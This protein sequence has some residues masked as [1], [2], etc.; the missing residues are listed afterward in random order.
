MTTHGLS[1]D[2]LQFRADFEEC[3]LAP[4]VFGHRAHLRLAYVYLA[5]NDA[6]AAFGLMRDALRRFLRH[7]GIDPTKY[8]ET[9][10]RAWLLAV[11]HFM[12]RT[13]SASSAAAFIDANPT[14]L[15]AK[16]MMTHYS[17]ELLFSPEARG[18]FVE[19]DLAQI[20]RHG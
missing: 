15:D 7:H 8:H 18:Q 9:L 4:E 17:A 3:R 20:P 16:I 2:D 11:R 12:E 5:E 14:L 13:A 19:P 1:A 10:T 6:D